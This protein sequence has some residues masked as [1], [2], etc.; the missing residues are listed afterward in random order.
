MFQRYFLLY[1]MFVNY[2]SCVHVSLSALFIIKALSHLAS[3]KQEHGDLVDPI[4]VTTDLFHVG[5]ILYVSDQTP[6]EFFK[7][8]CV[9]AV[10]L[11]QFSL[12]HSGLLFSSIK[13]KVKGMEKGHM[14][15]VHFN[16]LM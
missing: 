13:H 10:R 12:I 11:C 7:M 8:Q 3:H 5:L 14:A 6:N 15:S 2:V 16:W 4:L 9:A 1:N